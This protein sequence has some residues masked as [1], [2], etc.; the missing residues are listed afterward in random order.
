MWYA[1]SARLQFPHF[2]VDAESEYACLL[3]STS[4]AT[5]VSR[6]MQFALRFNFQFK[7][8]ILW[9]F[10]LRLCRYIFGG[11][12]QNKSLA[13]NL[14]LRLMLKS[15]NC[16]FYVKVLS[17]RDISIR[18]ILSYIKSSDYLKEIEGISI[19]FTFAFKCSFKQIP[20]GFFIHT[21][22]CTIYLCRS[23]VKTH[24]HSSWKLKI[25]SISNSTYF[26]IMFNGVGGW[27]ALMKH[28]LFILFMQA[29]SKSYITNEIVNPNP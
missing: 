24:T 23:S 5:N 10:Y 29:A 26:G 27:P 4:H 28:F 3:A 2:F 15:W 18:C 13:D 9:I 12:H 16:F 14:S 11:I 8:F 22:M 6:L 17:E 7:K 20:P 25:Y 1:S 21:F 19:T